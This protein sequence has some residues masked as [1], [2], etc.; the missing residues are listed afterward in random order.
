MCYTLHT[1]PNVCYIINTNH[2][3]VA[4]ESS[5]NMPKTRIYIVDDSPEICSTLEKTIAFLPNISILGVSGTVNKAIYDLAEQEPEMVILDINLPDGS[6]F[7][8]LKF[9]KKSKAH[10]PILILTNHSTEPFRRRAQQY[11]AD[12]FFD[13]TNEFENAIEVLESL[14]NP[15]QVVNL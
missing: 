1:T 14:S 7:D 12:F 6:G 9:M 10:I 3:I 8:V 4:Q 11:G 2:F 15:T 5:G 13:K